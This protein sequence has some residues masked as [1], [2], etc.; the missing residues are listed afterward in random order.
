MLIVLS[1]DE[2]PRVLFVALPSSVEPIMLVSRSFFEAMVSP[3][4]TPFLDYKPYRTVPLLNVRS[5][6]LAL[7][8]SFLVTSSTHR[9]HV[10]ATKLTL[11]TGLLLDM[12]LSEAVYPLCH[13]PH[14][15]MG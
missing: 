10:P 12:L 4:A 11:Y 6:L 8:I 3:S 15:R 7:M 13:P 9:P 14:A 1:V 2:T 5:T